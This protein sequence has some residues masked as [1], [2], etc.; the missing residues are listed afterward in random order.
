MSGQAHYFLKALDVA[1]RG[2]KKHPKAAATIAYLTAASTI[3]QVRQVSKEATKILAQPL[4]QGLGQS[5]VSAIRPAQK[6]S[7]NIIRNFSGV[8]VSQADKISQASQ[9]IAK[10]VA[11]IFD[12]ALESLST[13]IDKHIV[14]ALGGIGAAGAGGI[15][16]SY[17]APYI[18]NKRY[19]R[20]MLNLIAASSS[21]IVTYVLLKKFRNKI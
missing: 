16:M 17:L 4:A 12:T 21:G 6:Q 3:P 13:G 20:N 19:I 1:Q 18:T 7:Q 9:K 2:I 8:L 5:V 14:P 11:Q 15:L 10:P